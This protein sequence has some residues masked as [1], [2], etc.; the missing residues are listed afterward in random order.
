MTN[1]HEHKDTR[2]LTPFFGDWVNAD[3]DATAVSRIRCTPGMEGGVVIEVWGAGAV[4][5]PPTE[6]VVVYGATADTDQA[7]G[8]TARVA[9]GSTH[10]HLQANL[11][12]GVMVVAGF[13]AA[14]AASTFS[15]EFLALRSAM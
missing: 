3:P 15:R 2:S 12:G 6:D 1:E 4:L 9:R 8:F 5:W 14:D 13:H 7:T 10:T 11:K